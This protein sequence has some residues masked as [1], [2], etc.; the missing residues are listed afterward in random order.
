MFRVK[1]ENAL[2]CFFENSLKHDA[3]TLSS[4]RNHL[5]EAEK[6]NGIQCDEPP[7]YVSQFFQIFDYLLRFLWEARHFRVQP[8]S[9]HPIMRLRQNVLC[10]YAI[11]AHTFSHLF[12]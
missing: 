7:Q 9:D 2:L 8:S 4:D 12:N 11:A 10:R 6:V 3:W 5:Q 1:Q